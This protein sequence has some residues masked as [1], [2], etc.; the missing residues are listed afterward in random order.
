MSSSLLLSFRECFEAVLIIGII[1]TYI[2]QTGKQKLKPYVYY[3]AIAGL[4]V[5]LISGFIS[6]NEAKELEEDGEEIFEG[7]M[8]LLASGLISYFVVWMA[9][10]NKNIASSLKDSVDKKSTA[11]GLFLL[12]FLS[13]FREGLEL[14]IFTLTK[15]NENASTIALGTVIGFGLA[16]VVGLII[17]KT[18][19]KLNI[20][21]IFKVLGLIII[22]IGADLLGEGLTKFFP[23]GGEV[24]E[25]VPCIIYS[26]LSLIYFLK[27]DFKNFHNKKQKLN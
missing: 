13:V 24:L 20:K 6:F 27:D 1:I 21:W 2:S 26:G 10:Q 8:M 7:I 3:G 9:N 14:V 4:V 16:I 5:S 12:A 15:I 17:F 19:M 23:N 18:S 25:I 11:F 22:F